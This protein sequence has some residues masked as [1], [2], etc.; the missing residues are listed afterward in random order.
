MMK[1]YFPENQYNILKIQKYLKSLT[2]A[3]CGQY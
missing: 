2:R 3:E 1:Q